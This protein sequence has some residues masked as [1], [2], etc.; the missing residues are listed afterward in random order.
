[1]PIDHMVS[2][3][4]P[5]SEYYLAY[6]ATG[7]EEYIRDMPSELLED[8]LGVLLFDFA[9]FDFEL[10]DKSNIPPLISRCVAQHPVHGSATNPSHPKAP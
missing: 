6:I 5:C 8:L 7:L 4:V 9:R 10:R 2:M 1:M 3:L